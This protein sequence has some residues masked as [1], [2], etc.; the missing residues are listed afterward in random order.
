MYQVERQNDGRIRLIRK[1]DG[2][3]RIHLNF[4]RKRKSPTASDVN[5]TARALL[6]LEIEK[7]GLPSTYD[8]ATLKTTELIFPMYFEP[9]F[10]K[11]RAAHAVLRKFLPSGDCKPF[12]SVA[13]ANQY[14]NIL[15]LQMSKLSC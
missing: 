2:G 8:N 13:L 4:G 9:S 1:I 15:D 10:D 12:H 14:M 3:E 11:L 7:A 5:A 6:Q